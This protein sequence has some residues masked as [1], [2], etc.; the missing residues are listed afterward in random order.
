M[1]HFFRFFAVIGIIPVIILY[2]IARTLLSRQRAFADAVQW[3]ALVPGLPGE[4]LRLAFLR[5]ALPRCGKNSCI[6]FGTIFSHP[7]AEL[8]ENIYIGPYCILGDI[9]LENDVLLASGVSVANGT[10]QHFI[11]RTDVPIRL[12]GGEFPRITIGEDSWVGERAI[13]LAN[14]GRHCVVGAGALVLENIPDYAIAVGVPAKVVKFRNA[15][16]GE[17]IQKQKSL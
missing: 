9:T 14:I 5:W 4:Y 12:Q 7:T 11:A 13:V 2:C 17:G 6:G 3:L 15:P 1:K 10:Q 16:N 8:G